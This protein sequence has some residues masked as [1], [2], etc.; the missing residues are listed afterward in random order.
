MVEIIPDVKR[1]GFVFSDGVGT[2]SMS[3]ARKIA[4][5]LPLK[6]KNTVPSCYQIRWAGAKGMK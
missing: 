6:D 1:N 4:E 5:K 2:I 3:L